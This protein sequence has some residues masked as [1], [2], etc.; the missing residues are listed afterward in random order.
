MTNK[1][2]VK[3][4]DPAKAKSPGPERAREDRQATSPRE[5]LAAE[6]FPDDVDPQDSNQ[7]KPMINARGKAGLKRG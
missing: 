2:M 4:V 7:L 5:G 3:S 6:Q 1:D